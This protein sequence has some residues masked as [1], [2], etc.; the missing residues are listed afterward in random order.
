MILE[1]SAIHVPDNFEVLAARS[2]NRGMKMFSFT[3]EMSSIL[4]HRYLPRFVASYMPNLVQLTI[5]PEAAKGFSGLKLW[6]M[7]D[8]ALMPSL[9]RLSVPLS[10]H[11]CGNNMPAVVYTLFKFQCLKFLTLS[12]GFLNSNESNMI[13]LVNMTEF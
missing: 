6:Q 7:A 5:E 1:R 8:F 3:G 11:D 4:V 12:W 10:V 13:K 2:V 9:Q